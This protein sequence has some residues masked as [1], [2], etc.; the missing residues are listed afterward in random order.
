MM[1]LPVPLIMPASHSILLAAKPSRSTLII[2]IPPATAASNATCTLCCSAS[3]KISLPCSASR[4]LLAV[5]TCLP[6]LI[7]SVTTSRATVMPPITS[8]TISTSS[9]R[10]I[11]SR[12]SLHAIPSSCRSGR[13]RRL[14]T[15]V[16][17]IS[18]PV[19]RV[20]SAALSCSRRNAPTPTV[21]NPKIARF[22]DFTLLLQPVCKA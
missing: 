2:G 8:M 18:R 9:A 17:R 20:I 11:D 15:W 21:P 10:T 7:A 13:S 19:R 5:T 3:A 1:K 4:A 12:S 22:T 14:P 6:C 16:I